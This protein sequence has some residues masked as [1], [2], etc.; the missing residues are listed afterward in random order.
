MYVI[1][2]AKE[3][4]GLSAQMS[5][6]KPKNWKTPFF[7]IW[8]GQAFSLLGSQLVQFAL[9]WYLTIQTGS[10]TVLATITMM[11]LL[12]G[13]FLSPFI[14]PLVDRWNRR[15]IMLVADASIAFVTFILALLFAF[16]V[17]QVW[18]IYVIMFIRAVGGNFHGPAMTSSTS[19]MVPKEHL[20][21][22]QG[23]NQTLNGGL[24]IVAAPLGAVLLELL[25]MKG[26][27]AID[28]VTA[29][30]AIAPLFFIPIPQPERELEEDGT[31]TSFFQ[32]LMQGFRY[33]LSW[34]GLLIV[35]IMATMINFLL[36]PATSL[37]PLLVKDH[38]QGDALKLGWMNSIFG[39]GVIVGGIAL[40]VWGGFKRRIVTA[41][42][43]LIGIGVGILLMGLIPGT[44][45]SYALLAMAITG[46]MMPITNGSLG[47]IMQATVDPGMQGR[48]F[49]LT[50][51]VATAM[52]PIGLV[53]A[54]V[55]SDAFGIQI[56]FLIG[57]I[58]TLLMGF[59]GFAMPAVM[60]IEDGP[61][62]RSDL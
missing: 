23:I 6:T 52:T 16:D 4:K 28:M 32:D 43:G 55:L 27:V 14:G 25:P 17:I 13:V 60:S 37:L 31:P 7:T 11:A 9:I 40:G 5:T 10:A 20:T 29:L 61:R 19:L 42:M 56:W 26:I 3:F 21:R 18:H 34:R 47:G 46:I 49:S 39:I 50:G 51:S 15:L 62:G 54:G 59:V 1:P 53:I 22:I 24:N 35:L 58:V 48:V 2:R 36:S 38:F 12:P 41:M 45:F 44:A 33:V 57:G 30:I 8:T